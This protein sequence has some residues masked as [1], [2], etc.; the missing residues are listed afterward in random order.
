[1][2]GNCFTCLESGL[3]FYDFCSRS[4]LFGNEQCNCQI[5][6]SKVIYPRWHCLSYPGMLRLPLWYWLLIHVV[7]KWQHVLD[8]FRH[9]KTTTTRYHLAPTSMTWGGQ[10]TL[11]KINIAHRKKW[12]CYCLSDDSV[13]Y[14]TSLEKIT[15]R[16]CVSGDLHMSDIQNASFERA[17]WADMLPEGR[18]Q[19][20][21]FFYLL[22]TDYG[23]SYGWG[24]RSLP[25]SEVYGDLLAFRYLLPLGNTLG[26]WIPERLLQWS[27]NSLE[28]PWWRRKVRGVSFGCWF[29]SNQ[30]GRQH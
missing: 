27:L 12:T 16:R 23:R 15:W 30:Y 11:S 14:F 22:F 4:G 28:D 29:V 1:M 24:T 2:Q 18:L 6:L 9:L 13:N 10:I 5:E 25:T 20:L 19:W 3:A 8:C 7:S 21:P 26:W 17:M